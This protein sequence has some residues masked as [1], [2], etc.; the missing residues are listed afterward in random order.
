MKNKKI[1][2]IKLSST[3]AKCP[4]CE[5]GCSKCKNGFLEVGFEKGNMFTR[6]CQN[7]KCSLSNG[8][9]I[10]KDEFPGGKQSNPGK[11]VFCHGKTKWVL[12]GKSE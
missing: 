12:I 10:T 9:Y 3:K 4:Y 1:S 11:C 8:V 7:K 5:N 2:K 6:L